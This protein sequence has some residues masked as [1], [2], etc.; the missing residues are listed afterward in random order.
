MSLPVLHTDKLIIP[1]TRK[2]LYLLYTISV[3]MSRRKAKNE[4]IYTES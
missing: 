4:K 2:G 1:Q 3:A